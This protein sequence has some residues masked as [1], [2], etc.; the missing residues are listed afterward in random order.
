M[1]VDNRRADHAI[2]P[3]QDRDFLL[4]HIGRDLAKITFHNLGDTAWSLR[5]QQ[6]AKPHLAYRVA[7]RVNHKQKV[8]FSILKR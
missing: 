2:A 7:R 5:T 8:K 3:E 4:V 6:F 1:L